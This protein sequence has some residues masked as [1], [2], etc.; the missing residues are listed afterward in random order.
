ME[1][2]E[3][4][5]ERELARGGAR[6][7]P[8]LA[9]LASA[10]RDAVGESVA[11]NAWPLRLGR[12]GTLHVATTSS[13]WAFELDR[14]AD[15]IARKLE[16]QLGDAAPRKL[17]FAV[18]PVPEPATTDAGL[19]RSEP[20]VEVSPRADA[21]AAAAAAEIADPDLRELALRAARASLSRPPSDRTF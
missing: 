11:R 7:A 18:G 3:R 21:E 5:V 12:D 9:S 17:R 6:D 8:V 14:L 1:R 15:E 10:W 19:T 2:I 20:R 13:T 16:S 4:L